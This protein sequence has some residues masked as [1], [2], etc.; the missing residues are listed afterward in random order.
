MTTARHL[1]AGALLLLAG[2][3]ARGT[4]AVEATGTVEMTE[5]DVVPTVPG[6][7]G[8]LAV[9]EGATVR[10]GDTVAVVS[11]SSLPAE[12]LQREAAVARAR[13]EL[14]DLAQGARPEEVA[15]AEAGLR[16]AEA[17]AERAA[18]DFARAG[19]LA[20][21]GDVSR[22]QLDAA[23]AAALG[24]AA[25][26]DAARSGLALLRA[27][28]RADVVRAARARLAQE[29]AALAAARAAAGDHVLLA[30]AGGRV[31]AVYAEV[32]E[33]AVAGRPVLS[34]TDD[35]RPWV[36][37]F[38]SQK[39]LGGVQPGQHLVARLD[40]DARRFPARV[41]SLN[42]EAEF[43]PRVALTEDER[44]DLMFGVK[45]ALGGAPGELHAGVP[46]TVELR[47]AGADA[48]RRFAGPPAAPRVAVRGPVA[49]RDEP[50]DAAAEARP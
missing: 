49:S 1:T 47:P 21:A 38:V 39:A 28:A 12:L 15:R 16:A 36:R 5:V 24:S 30:P 11:S 19:R 17:E 45:V 33:P 46:I 2:A 23:R 41:V 29:E 25:R 31:R 9:A 14:R 42:P 6:R 40:G 27:G 48:G 8:R 35:A 13:A 18:A 10:P 32:G 3:C 50:R 37:V 26:R 7:I 43:T 4:P 44:A 34:I 20:A 22:Q